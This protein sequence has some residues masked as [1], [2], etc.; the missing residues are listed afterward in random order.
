MTMLT[1]NSIAELREKVFAAKA[2]G[3]K[4]GF[5][6]TMGNL[7]EGHI[8]LVREAR[9]TT[10]FTVCS[11][12]VNP[13]QFGAGEDL[14]S[15]PRTLEAD[16]EKLEAAG[17][18][19]LFAPSVEEMYP[20]G[21]EPVAKVIVP[22]LSDILC[23]R[24]RPIHFTGVATVVSKLFNMAQPD[25]AFFGEK[26]FQQLTVIKA[27]TKELCFPV[28]VVGVPTVRETNGLAMSSRNGYLSEEEKQQAGKIFQLLNA[29]ADAIR[30][31][32]FIISMETIQDLCDKAI[33]ELAEAGFEPDYFSIR[34]QSDL[35]LPV[36][37]DANLVILVAAKLGGARL[38]DNL[39]V[40]LM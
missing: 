23:G 24:S 13:T 15:Y 31:P 33:I 39:K 30:Q 2:A 22:G 17:L 27:F 16:K 6:P 21:A 7:H 34:R 32:E 14:D 11:I 36:S 3:K 19:L 10:D 37:S 20:N 26:D 25:E 18:D 9:K 40:D 29:T 12:F 5:V 8:T 4:V 1:V 28:K 38:I 35:Q